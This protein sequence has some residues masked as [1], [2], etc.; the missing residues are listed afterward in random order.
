MDTEAEAP[1]VTHM[2]T[3]L[4]VEGD[5]H[6]DPQRGRRLFHSIPLGFAISKCGD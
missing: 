4:T 1:R 5:Q 3:G 6:P 2:C